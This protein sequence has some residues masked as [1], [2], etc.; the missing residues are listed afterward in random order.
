MLDLSECVFIAEMRPDDEPRISALKKVDKEWITEQIRTKCD[1]H[2]SSGEAFL[3]DTILNSLE[4][5]SAEL[6]LKFNS[7]HCSWDVSFLASSDDIV[8]LIT[9]LCT[10]GVYRSI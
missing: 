5:N 3:G 8:A 6:D 9:F 10:Y 7:S 1:R 2:V 4:G